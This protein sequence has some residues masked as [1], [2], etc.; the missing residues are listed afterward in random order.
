MLLRFPN[1]VPGARESFR[2]TKDA[3]KC[4]PKGKRAYPITALV[5]G[6]PAEIMI[7]SSASWSAES[8]TGANG[9]IK[10]DGKVFWFLFDPGFIPLDGLDF[11]LETGPGLPNPKREPKDPVKEAAR[12]AACSVTL[13]A[14]AA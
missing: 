11:R 6:T 14:R 8:T 3:E 7:T 2:L 12:T 13:R 10:I 1:P 4:Y 9:W 5:N